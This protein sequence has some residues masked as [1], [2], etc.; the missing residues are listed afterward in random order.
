MGTGKS[1]GQLQCKTVAVPGRS[2]GE[3]GQCPQPDQA[4]TTHFY[5]GRGSSY[6]FV[7]I[8][9]QQIRRCGDVEIDDLR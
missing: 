1:T 5:F 4:C 6:A 2:A 8:F 3:N 9:L 7:A